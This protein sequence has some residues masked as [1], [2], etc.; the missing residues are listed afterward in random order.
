MTK[1]IDQLRRDAKAPKKAFDA[2][3]RAAWVR[4]N[5]YRPRPEGT[6]LKTPALAPTTTRLD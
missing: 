1:S 6:P 4:V 3:D 5:N 2:G